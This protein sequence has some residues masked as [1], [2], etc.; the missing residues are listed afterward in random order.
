MKDAVLVDGGVWTAGV[1][2][3]AA[4]RGGNA[5]GYPMPV[6][7]C[8]TNI[9]MYMQPQG[10]GQ[11]RVARACCRFAPVSRNVLVATEKSIYDAV[12]GLERLGAPPLNQ[13]R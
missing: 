2:S 7:V 11:T 9:R 8:R 13:H 5:R 10:Q 6:S 1:L 4:K 12:T 3:A